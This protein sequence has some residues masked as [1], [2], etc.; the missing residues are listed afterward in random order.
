MI[1]LFNQ[2]DTQFLIDL[3]PF[4]GLGG[5]I[6]LHDFGNGEVAT[7]VFYADLGD[8]TYAVRWNPG[9]EYTIYMDESTLKSKALAAQRKA[10]L[11][12]TAT[13]LSD[14]TFRFTDEELGII[15]DID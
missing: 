4:V 14:S 2:F 9:D 7:P 8:G 6:I 12:S 3:V 5:M 13:F 15:E 11:T 1:E 10:V